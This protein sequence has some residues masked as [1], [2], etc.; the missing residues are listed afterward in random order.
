MK[1]ENEKTALDKELTS[2]LERTLRLENELFSAI[3]ND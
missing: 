1:N 3:N 2:L